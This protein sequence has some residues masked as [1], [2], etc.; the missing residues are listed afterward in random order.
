ME[1]TTVK[2]IISDEI[3]QARFRLVGGVFCR[4]VA[5]R[6]RNFWKTHE[7]FPVITRKTRANFVMMWI[8]FFSS[9][10]VDFHPPLRSEKDTWYS[11]DAGAVWKM[12]NIVRA[13]IHLNFKCT[14]TSEVVR[15]DRKI[16]QGAWKLFKFHTPLR[17]WR[18]RYCLSLTFPALL[19]IL[20]T[21]NSRRTDK[22]SKKN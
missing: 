20:W 8:F 7:D 11:A 3:R 22:K 6:G 1:L 16:S 21:V 5:A 2:K 18:C 13:M 17:Y 12:Y 19:I 10:D 9:L 15:N 4:Y 14:S